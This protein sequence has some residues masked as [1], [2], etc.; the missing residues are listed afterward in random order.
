MSVTS[1]W[2]KLAKAGG[3]YEQKQTMTVIHGTVK[4]STDVRFL[5]L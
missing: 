3:S 1:S 4:C 5:F 2:Q